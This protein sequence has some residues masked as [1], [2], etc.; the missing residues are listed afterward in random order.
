M[1]WPWCERTGELLFYEFLLKSKIQFFILHI[2]DMLKF[3]L[4]DKYELDKVRF[5][6]L[7]T[8]KE[9]MKKDNAVKINYISGEDHFKFISLKLA[10]TPDYDFLV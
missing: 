9:E 4:G 5:S 6:E 8:W 7:L 2:V 3:M 10:N 1:I